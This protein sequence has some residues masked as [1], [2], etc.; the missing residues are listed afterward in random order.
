MVINPDKIKRRFILL[1]RCFNL[2]KRRFNFFKRLYI[3]T[4]RCVIK[5]ISCQDSL[6]LFLAT[7]FGQYSESGFRM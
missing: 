4:R 2:P 5:I 7:K 6:F 3:K 1:K